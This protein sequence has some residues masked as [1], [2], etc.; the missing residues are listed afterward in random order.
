MRAYLQGCNA[1]SELVFQTRQE[2][3]AALHKLVY[4]DLRNHFALKS[5]MAQ[6]VIKTVIASYK[7]MESDHRE[8]SLV[9]YKRPFVDLVRGR[10]YSIVK[11]QFSVNTLGG[12]AKVSFV[13]TGMSQYLDGSWDW[14]TARLLCKNRKWFLHIPMTKDFPEADDTAIRQVVGIDLGLNFLATTYDSQGKT[15]FSKGR[16][17][18][19]KRNHF[20]RLRKQLQKKQTPAAR[21]RLKAIGQ[22]E[23]RWMTDINHA[24]TKT[25]VDRYGA[26]TLFVLEDLTAIR[27]RSAKLNKGSKW[28]VNHWAFYQFRQFLE[29]KAQLNQSKVIFV[30]PVFSS[31]TCPKCGHVEKAN[32]NKHDHCF[33]CRNCHYRS[34]DDRIGAMNL[35]QKGVSYIASQAGEA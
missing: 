27:D 23:N 28:A 19:H 34:N 29:Y 15:A 8:R 5:Q 35:Q 7:T 1:V 17:L 2:K 22:R 30:D 12:R 16:S 6:S 26:N 18:L 31:Q 11:D 4:R 21:R 3:Q 13:R 14:G 24:I 20:K 10:D 33:E 9:Q 25:L 32:R